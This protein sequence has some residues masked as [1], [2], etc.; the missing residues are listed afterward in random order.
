MTNGPGT[1]WH[2]TLL[3][4]NRP[5]RLMA[6]TEAD[7][8]SERRPALLIE[9]IQSGLLSVVLANGVYLHPNPEPFLGTEP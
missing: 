7:V 2:R 8:G 1:G 6:I 9:D 3:H 5:H 4:S